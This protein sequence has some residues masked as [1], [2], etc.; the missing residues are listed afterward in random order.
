MSE[1]APVLICASCGDPIREESY[2]RAEGGAVHVH[3]TFSEPC[4]ACG[5]DLWEDGFLWM[6]GQAWHALCAKPLSAPAVVSP[7]VPQ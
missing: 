1:S 3:C 2:L 6:A 4:P 7:L 5:R